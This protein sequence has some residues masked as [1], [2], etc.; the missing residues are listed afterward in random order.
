MRGGVGDESTHSQV[1][2]VESG[3]VDTVCRMAGA[4]EMEVSGAYIA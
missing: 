4:L 3:V 1:Q 2:P